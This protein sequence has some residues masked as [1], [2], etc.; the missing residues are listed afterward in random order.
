[1]HVLFLLVACN[2]DDKAVV[3]I[4]NLFFGDSGWCNYTLKSVWASTL[5]NSSCPHDGSFDALA[6]NQGGLA[7]SQ[8]VLF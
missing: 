6:D 1:M 8:A 4:T 5:W 3:K 2:S 7:S